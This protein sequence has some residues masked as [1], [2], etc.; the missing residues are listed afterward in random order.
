MRKNRSKYAS[1]NYPN[2]Y[3]YP[4]SPYWIFRKWSSQKRQ[5]FEFSTKE[6]KNE[7]RAYRIGRDAFDEWLGRLA[8]T[9][10]N[11][12]IRDIARAMLE[13]KAKRAEQHEKKTGRA[14]E[15]YRSFRNQTVNHLVPAIGHLRPEQATPARW[16]S[17]ILER[18]QRHPDCKLFNLRKTLNMIQ[19]RAKQEGLLTEIPKYRNPDPKPEGAKYLKDEAVRLLI[20]AASRTTKLLIL[21]MWKQGAR[22][23]EVLQ[24]RWDMIRWD[25]GEMGMIHIP[26]AITKTRRPRA[27][28]MNSKVSR[29]LRWL[30]PRSESP[31]L[32][33]SPTSDSKPMREYK[34]GWNG[35]IRRANKILLHRRMKLA[36]IKGSPYVLRDTWAFNCAKRNVN[37]IFAAKYADTSVKMLEKH[38]VSAEREAME[39][40]AG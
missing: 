27:I 10:R 21:I 24:Y 35:A 4:D 7:A 6:A 3:R 8:P 40:V 33:P 38:Y 2:L 13:E 36:P 18:R 5:E 12:T 16:E 39:V 22:P 15:T 26:G 17:V 23:G 20:R 9:S 11:V 31:F 29:I 32:F 34:T 37:I 19:R 30:A 14:D 25:E 28:P 1:K